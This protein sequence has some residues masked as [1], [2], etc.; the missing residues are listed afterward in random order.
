MPSGLAPVRLPI[1]EVAVLFLLSLACTKD[2][3]LGDDT[4]AD[5]ELLGILIAPESLI[6]PIGS[7]A[8]LLSLIHI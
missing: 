2:G 1:T 3:I 5:K 4:A 7:T 8:Q 6:V